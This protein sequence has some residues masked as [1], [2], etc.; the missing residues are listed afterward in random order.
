MSSLEL[1]LLSFLGVGS[2]LTVALLHLSKKY[3]WTIALYVTQSLMIT[4][5]LVLL[6]WEAQ[7]TA[8]FLSAV[9]SFAVKAIMAPL[10]FVRLI[11]QYHIK[12]TSA[13]YLNK[14]LT[15]LILLGLT[16]F[17][18]SPVFKEFV[19]FFGGE[20]TLISVSLATLFSSLFLIINRK[21]AVSQIIAILSF[22][23]SIIFLISLLGVEQSFGLELGILFDLILWIVIANVM[24]AAMFKQFGS[25][26]VSG[27]TRLKE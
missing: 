14:T 19:T 11:R 6:A 21:D 7:S 16:I 26:D 1:S 13:S 5:S 2:F 15:L 23:N 8:T 27:M 22:E 10:F 24:V 3:T 12:F 17:A 18:Y 9:L 20:A 4:A 25:L